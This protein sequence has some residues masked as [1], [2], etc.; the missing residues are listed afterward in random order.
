MLVANQGTT[1]TR[2]AIFNHDGFMVGYAYP[3]HMQIHP[4]PFWVEY[5]PLEIR[6]RPQQVIKEV[7]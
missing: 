4:K 3:E 7:L 1:G 6:E 5:N 2:A